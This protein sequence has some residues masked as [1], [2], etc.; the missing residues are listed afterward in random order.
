MSDGQV[1]LLSFFIFRMFDMKKQYKFLK[2]I[3]KIPFIG[4]CM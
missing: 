3:D 1:H 4:L 2:F